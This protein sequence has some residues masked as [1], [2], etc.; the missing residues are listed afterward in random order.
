[1]PE[2]VTAHE[3]ARAYIVAPIG[4]DDCPASNC[5]NAENIG[6]E[7]KCDYNL[8]A[9]LAWGTI[10]PNLGAVE[11]LHMLPRLQLRPAQHG[12]RD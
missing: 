4:H 5:P 8:C 11:I 7:Y 3:Q 12:A 10:A 1:M 2:L 9:R 6:V